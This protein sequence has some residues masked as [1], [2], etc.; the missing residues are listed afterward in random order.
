MEKRIFKIPVGNLSNEET[1]KL[2][3]KNNK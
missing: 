1:E 2:I 3:K